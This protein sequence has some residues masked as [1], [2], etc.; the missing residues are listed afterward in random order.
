MAEEINKQIT[1]SMEIEKDIEETR[2]SFRSV[3]I[4]GSIIFFVIKDLALIDP[5]Y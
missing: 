5:M 4:R 1:K 2:N 3:S